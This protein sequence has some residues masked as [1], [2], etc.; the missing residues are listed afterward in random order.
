MVEREVI[1]SNMEKEDLAWTA[2]GPNKQ[3]N[4]QTNK[5]R[6]KTNA[7]FPDQCGVFNKGDGLAPSVLISKMS[8]ALLTY[9]KH[10]HN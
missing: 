5:Q 10:I 4:K 6:P 3:T 7:I 2:L 1:E 8:T 9:C